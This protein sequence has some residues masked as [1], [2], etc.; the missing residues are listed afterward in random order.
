MPLEGVPTDE[1]VVFD[2]ALIIRDLFTGGTRTFTS[3]QDA[4]EFRAEVY[5]NY[6]EA[7]GRCCFSGLCFFYRQ[8]PLV[9]ACIS[10]TRVCPDMYY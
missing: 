8:M 5:R 2:R 3:T 4:R 7:A 6:G 1:W 9:Q 10:C